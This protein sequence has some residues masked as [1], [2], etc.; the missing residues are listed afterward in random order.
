M[1]SGSNYAS[2]FRQKIRLQRITSKNPPCGGSFEF[3]KIVSQVLF[4]DDNLSKPSNL[5]PWESVL[6]TG[7]SEVAAGRIAPFH[8]WLFT[9]RVK[10]ST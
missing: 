10:G 7:R 3:W 9:F 4:L 2:G 1:C 5:G 8:S 6:K